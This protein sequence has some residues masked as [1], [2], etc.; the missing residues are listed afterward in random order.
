[1]DPIEHLLFR[2]KEEGS[3]REKCRR[4]GLPETADSA[5]TQIRDAIGIRVVCSF[6]D[7]IYDIRLFIICSCG[8]IKEDIMV[9]R[10]QTARN[11]EAFHSSPPK[12]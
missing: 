10:Q 11:E 6:L 4:K 8:R 9:R 2:I 3:M 7:D 5:L 1:M 12:A